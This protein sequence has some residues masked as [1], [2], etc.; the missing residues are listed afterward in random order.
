MLP[1]QSAWIG[2]STCPVGREKRS[3]KRYLRKSSALARQI[4]GVV[5]EDEVS[6]GFDC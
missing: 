6:L 2:W 4:R 5:L 3:K 1:V